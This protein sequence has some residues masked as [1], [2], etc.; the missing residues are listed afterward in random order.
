MASPAS[1]VTPKKQ[2][3]TA[4]FDAEARTL[5]ARREQATAAAQWAFEKK[6]GS[7]RA[8]NGKDSPFKDAGLTYNMIEL[9]LREPSAR[10]L[11]PRL[12]LQA[13]VGLEAGAH[14]LHLL[15]QIPHTGQGLG[16]QAAPVP[17]P[18]RVCEHQPPPSLF[19]WFSGS[20]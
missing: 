1:T 5:K 2:Y 11:H 17:P 12:Q 9:L 13:L 4:F 14:A 20:P 6:F 19:F 8:A 7:K 18:R 10:V 3:T 16:V 15:H